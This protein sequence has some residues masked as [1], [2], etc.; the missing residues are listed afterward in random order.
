M[1]STE[2]SSADHGRQEQGDIDIEI[3]RRND[4]QE[5]D[6]KIR[7]GEERKGTRGG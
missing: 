1:Q 2:Q 3:G 7:K 4:Q 6:D 5:R